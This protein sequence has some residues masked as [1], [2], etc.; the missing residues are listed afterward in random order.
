MPTDI[1]RRQTT[2]QFRPV[3]A[4][5][6]SASRNLAGSALG[7]S[8]VIL[9]PVLDISCT[10]HWRAAKPPSKVIHPGCC[11]DLRDSRFVVMAALI[12]F[13][14]IALGAS[15]VT[16]HTLKSVASPRGSGMV[17]LRGTHIQ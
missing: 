6:V 3:R 5:R 13:V 7:S 14:F 9:A 8:I 10:R 1:P 11:R 15:W 4:S 17:A 16:E 12:F 2:S